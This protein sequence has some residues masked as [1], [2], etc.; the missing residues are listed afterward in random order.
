MFLLLQELFDFDDIKENYV[1]FCS[2]NEVQVSSVWKHIYVQTNKQISLSDNI[3]SV[4]HGTE[5]S[6]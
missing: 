2:Y 1:F 5:I 6:S 3:Q 4:C